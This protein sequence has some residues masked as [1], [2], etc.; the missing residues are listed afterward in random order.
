MEKDWEDSTPRRT[1]QMSVEKN[2]HCYLLAPSQGR[3]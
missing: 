2:V 3:C 1:P